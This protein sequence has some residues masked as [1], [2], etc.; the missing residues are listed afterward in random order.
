MLRD[1]EISWK[2]GNIL[3]ARMLQTLNDVPREYMELSYH[4][5]SD[6]I[7]CGMELSIG[8]QS[9]TVSRGIYKAGSRI[10]VLP[11]DITLAMDNL[12]D[13]MLYVLTLLDDGAELEY[14]PETVDYVTVNHLQL[15]IRPQTELV[16][17]AHIICK[18]RGNTFFPRSM[19]DLIKRRNIFD[20]LFCQYAGYREHTFHPQVFALVREY[21]KAKPQKHPLDYVFLTEIAQRGVLPL[22]MLRQYIEEALGENDMLNFR[23]DAEIMEYFYDAVSQLQFVGTV[24]ATNGYVPRESAAEPQSEGILMRP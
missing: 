1:Y 2:K 18:F 5:Y 10:L 4:Q 16:N 19:D 23:N 24:L 11:E 6:G 12:M 22:E 21:L 15:V 9:L 14:T 13:G 17:P 8:S 7:L 3:T 20:F